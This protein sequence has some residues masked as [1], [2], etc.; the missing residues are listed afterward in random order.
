MPYLEPLHNRVNPHLPHL[1]PQEPLKQA[2]FVGWESQP[3]RHPIH[4]PIHRN[5][6]GDNDVTWR[7]G[8]NEMP[9]CD[10]DHPDYPAGYDKWLQK[11]MDEPWV[12]ALEDMVKWT[13]VWV[14]TEEA[15]FREL[16]M[17]VGREVASSP[18][19]PSSAERLK[20]Y[21]SIATDGFHARRLEFWH[22][23]LSDLCEEDLD[24]FNT[25][26]WGPDAPVLLFRDD[27]ARRPNY[28]QAMC[29]RLARKD[30][31]A[32]AVLMFTGK[33]RHFKKSRRWT[34]TT[35]ELLKK[36]QKH[37]PAG[38][39]GVPVPIANCFR[40]REEHRYA[41]YTLFDTSPPIDPSSREDYITFHRQ[42]RRCAGVLEEWRIKVSKQ[43]HTYSYTPSD[44][45]RVEQRSTTYW[46]V[47]APRWEK[48]EIIG[49]PNISARELSIM[50]L[51]WLMPAE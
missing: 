35:A 17:R 1:A 36:L 18:D 22:W 40:P 45:G 46:T 14:G 7:S 37:D 34:G 43:R 16:R 8:I 42:M 39:D 23:R 2:Y 47:E 32:L 3:Y 5:D 28:W 50:V 44:G 10:A 38:L 12:H 4:D 21:Q 41:V 31:L 24:D 30:A 51:S 11:V 27:T 13:G 29:R 25:P 49:D 15:F 33:D 48:P 19:F 20:L 6:Q 26:G 9:E